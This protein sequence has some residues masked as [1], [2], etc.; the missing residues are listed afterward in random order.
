MT[1]HLRPVVD[2]KPVRR[3]SRWTDTELMAT[4]FPEPRWAVPGLLCEGLNILAGAPKLGKSWLSLGLGASIS[5]GEPALGVVDVDKG[6]VLY[7]A[8]EDTGRRLQRRRR[9]MLK[10]GGRPS[11]L[12][13]LETS[14]PPMTAGGDAV[15]VDWLEA[16]PAARLVIIDTFEKMRGTDTPGMSAYAADYLAAGRFKRIA[17]HYEVPILLIHHVR[18]QGHED[19]SA[20]VSGTNGLTGAA[21]S[22]LV[23]ERGRGEDTGVLHVTG[24]DVEEADYAMRFDSDTGAWT[25]LDGPAEDY[26]MADTRVRLIHHIRAYPGS[27]PADIAEALDIKPATVRKTLG[28]MV[29]DGQLRNDRGAYHPPSDTT[30]APDPS[31]LSLCHSTSVDQRERL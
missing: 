1:P 22:I 23:L 2:A 3:Q 5:T 10:A 16:N 25:K 31:H 9:H 7:C 18:K 13:T 6:P 15:I 30:P 29:T 8:L 19:W 11:P 4:Q 27:K 26:L 24:R 21:D 14:C 12:L 28:R 20:L 17:D